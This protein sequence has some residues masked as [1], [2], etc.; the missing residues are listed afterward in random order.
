MT[1]S[2]DPA[3]PHDRHSTGYVA[4]WIRSDVTRDE[5]RRVHLRRMLGSAPFPPE[6]PLEVLDV[7]AGYGVV[8]EEVLR[9]FPSARVT[10]Q[11]YS[12]P[13]LDHARERLTRHADRVRYVLADLYDPAWTQKLGQRFDMAVSAIAVHNLR[14]EER[15]AEVYREV[16]GVLEPGGVF[17]D[18]DLVQIAGGAEVN[19]EWLRRG[20]FVDVGCPWQEGPY[21]VL[22][23]HAPK[24]QPG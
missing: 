9:A 1:A 21:A 3:D 24:A 4:E 8:S 19:L 16:L 15:I 6:A 5:E 7:G 14:S 18:Y 13:M 17:L 23:A 11:D 10:L 20:G 12:V 22:V 2:I